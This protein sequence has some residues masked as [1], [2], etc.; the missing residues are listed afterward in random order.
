MP[1]AQNKEDAA[2]KSLIIGHLRATAWSGRANAAT[3]TD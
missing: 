1:I 2:T 3:C